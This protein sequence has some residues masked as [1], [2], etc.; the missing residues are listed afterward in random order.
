[1]KPFTAKLNLNT[2]MITIREASPADI[3]IIKEIAYGSWPSTYG[4][5]LS[6]EQLDYMLDKFYDSG[7]LLDLMINQWHF[8]ILIYFIFKDSI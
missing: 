4:K 3:S 6:K 8:F 5:I 7:V 1:M 2:Q